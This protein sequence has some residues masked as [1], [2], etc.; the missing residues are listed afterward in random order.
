MSKITK[1]ARGE[2]CAVRIA[3]HAGL[4]C[5]ETDTTVFCH[6]PCVDKGAS[7]K[8]PDEFGAYGCMTCH[9]LID[10][11]AWP[12][13]YPSASELGAKSRLARLEW[14][15]NKAE[16]WLR[17]IYETQKKLRAKGLIRFGKGL[18]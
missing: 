7:I 15:L 2:D 16:G 9:D 3:G 12:Y 18:I 6:A 8:G 17:G 1:S 10:G 13:W 5:A 4:P 14:N 11:K